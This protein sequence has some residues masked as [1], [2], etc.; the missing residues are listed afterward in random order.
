MNSIPRWHG[1]NHFNHIVSISFSDGTK[2]EDI[3]KV[4]IISLYL[5][6]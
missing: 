4:S 6:E 2:Y 5:L 3:S 1:L